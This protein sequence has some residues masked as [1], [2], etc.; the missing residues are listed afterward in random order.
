MPPPQG[1]G[2]RSLTLPPPV[3]KKCWETEAKVQ[4]AFRV[5]DDPKEFPRQHLIVSQ[6]VEE[7]YGQF[8][9]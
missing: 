3:K 2:R 7:D 5:G 4:T 9:F 6:S 1:G 8:I